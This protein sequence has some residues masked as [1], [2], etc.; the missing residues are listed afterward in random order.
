M[1]FL[2]VSLFL[3]AYYDMKVLTWC[4][5][6][7]CLVLGRFF[8]ML[9]C[10]SHT[11]A[12]LA[13]GCLCLTSLV[14]GAGVGFWLD[15]ECLQRYWEL[16][17]GMEYKDVNPTDSRTPVDMGVLHFIAGTFVDNRR[18]IGYVV[19]GGIFCVAPVALQ[20]HFNTTVTYWAV[21]EVCCQ[22]RSGFDWR[23]KGSRFCD[24]CHGEAGKGIQEGHRGGS[25]SL[26]HQQHCEQHGDGQICQRP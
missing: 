22:M 17:N 1:F 6:S 23:F 4:I 24:C 25:V 12:F 9:G 15:K 3:F 5:M 13:V 11:G 16:D 14:V 8:L 19:D 18:T 21:G 26:R 7:A 10:M 20:A 2:V